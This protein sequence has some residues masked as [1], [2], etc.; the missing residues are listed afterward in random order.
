M[1]G[2]GQRPNC[3]SG[4]HFAKRAQQRC[5]QRSVPASNFAH[6]QMR[7]QHALPTPRTLSRQMGATDQ[8]R[9]KW[10]SCCWSFLLHGFRLCGGD[11]RA[12]RSPSG[13]LRTHTHVTWI[14]S[15]MR[16]V[17]VPLLLLLIHLRCAFRNNI[18]RTLLDFQ[19]DFADIFPDDT[20]KQTLHPANEAYQTSQ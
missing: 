13:L 10:F 9:E 2:L 11:Q 17:G 6:P 12:L 4:D 5:R 18:P 3:S 15:K 16:L 1:W 19:V 14:L 8:H 7:P 20:E